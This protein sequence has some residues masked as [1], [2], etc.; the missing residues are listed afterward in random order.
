MS[1][2]IVKKRNVAVIS[3][4]DYLRQIA[5]SGE[6]LD[7][8]LTNNY[9]FRKIFKNKRVVKGF[10]MPL[11]GLTEG[12]ITEVEVIDP[13]EEGEG[14][15]EKEGILDI[16]IH[17]N[18]N[19]KINIEMQ[20]Q[21][22]E[23]WSE[24]SIFYNCRMFTEGF[25]HGSAYGAME[26]CIHVGILNFNQLKG[27]GF[28]HCIMLKDVKTGELYSSKFVFH[29]IEL[30]KLEAASDEERKLE[31]YRWARLIA[32][33]SW[34]AVCME[35]KG[36]PYMEEAL[37]EMDKI[38]QSEKERYLYLRREMAASDEKSR[39]IT[40][41]NKGIEKGVEKTI[42]ALIET[43]KEVGFSREDSIDRIT[44]KLSISR[45]KAEKYIDEYWER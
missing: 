29:M 26:P 32:A 1:N 15:E 38:N 7:I 39:L 10:V 5:A 34:E 11:L 23:D 17:L 25:V 43:F 36:N 41:E 40:A 44:H 6:P 21:Y 13:Y 24:R 42:T 12:Q 18:N 35:A 45:E 9:A 31:L 22:Q 3:R 30:K 2:K 28:H 16:K 20:N 8:C 37:G 27:R 14:E 4:E 33:K 19:H